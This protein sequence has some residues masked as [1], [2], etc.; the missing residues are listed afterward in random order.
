MLQYK[1]LLFLLHYIL[2][3]G[4]KL[5]INYFGN[6][7]S[8]S[9]SYI[10]SEGFVILPL[11]GPVNLIGLTFEEATAYI[12]NQ[13]SQKLIGTDVTIS[14]SELRSI[15]VYILGEAYKPG[16]YTLSGLSSLQMPCL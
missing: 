9:E 4:D 3:P 6:E 8:Q 1:T 10:S 5:R 15:S 7:E 12:K 14:L 16:K 2:G 13:V 11:I